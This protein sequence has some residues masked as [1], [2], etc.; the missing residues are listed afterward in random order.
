M[1]AQAASASG[2]E[3]PGRRPDQA[4]DVNYAAE[5]RG[6]ALLEIAS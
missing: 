2:G 3:A 1:R 6:G 5:L 4:P